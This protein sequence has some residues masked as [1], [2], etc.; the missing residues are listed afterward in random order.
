MSQQ[1][2]NA[3]GWEENK[4]QEQ[5][6]PALPQQIPAA[7]AMSATHMPLS[8][9][10]ATDSADTEMP[11]G[12]DNTTA[13]LP[14]RVQSQ[15]QNLY[16]NVPLLRGQIRLLQLLPNENE[17][18]TIQCRLFR[19]ALDSRGTRL[20]EALSYVWGSRDNRRSIVVNGCD[21]AV[22]ENLY[23]ALL[24]LRD[25]SVERT[26]WIDAIC[27]NQEDTEEKG[28]QVQS[29]AKIYAKATRIIVWLGEEAAGSDQ[30][31]EE[32]RLAADVERYTRRPDNY[33]GILA[34]LQRSW[35][36][37]IWVLQEVA[38]AR[39]ILIK[40][41]SAEVDGYAFCLGL[42]ALKISKELRPNLRAR[43]L[44]VTYLIRGAIFRPKYTTT[45][46]T[47]NFSLNIRPLGELSEMY[48]TRE[49]TDRR[50]KVYALLGMSSD[51]PIAAGLSADYTISWVQLLNKVIHFSLS[52]LLFVGLWDNQENA[53]IEGKGCVL[54]EVSTV[55]KNATWEDKQDVVITWRKVF[56]V[57]VSRWSILTTEKSIQ[58]GDIVCLLQG[59]SKPTIL[60][61]C[62]YHWV[63]IMIAVYLEN[64]LQAAT[65]KTKW[66]ELWESVTVFPHDFQLRW[67]LDMDLDGQQDDNDH[68]CFA[69]FPVPEHSKSQLKGYVNAATRIR[70]VRLALYGEKLSRVA[71]KHL[72][73][74]MA[75]L[76]KGLRSMLTLKKAGLSP[77]DSEKEDAKKL[78]T[79]VNQLIDDLDQWWFLSLAA[80]HGHETFVKFLLDNYKFNPD[81]KT[82]ETALWLATREY[83]KGIAV[84]ELL[85][86]SGK[87]DVNLQ[88]DRGET[89]LH[90]AASKGHEDVVKL[91]LDSG[92]V[93]ANKQDENGQTALHRAAKRYGH[94]VV[95]KLLLDSGKADIDI[96]DGQGRTALNIVRRQAI[97]LMGNGPR[98]GG[99]GGRS[100]R[101]QAWRISP[102]RVR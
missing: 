18:A 14:V 57:P 17:D 78:E 81:A 56:D 72:R 51:N 100:P 64:D 29:M 20:Y 15:K 16:H 33:A 3:E 75:V 77:D 44:S 98:G 24:H 47:D 91:L 94:E 1:L 19:T 39:H 58:E 101:R 22:G 23:A 89:A 27:I 80:E 46:Q 76:E 6:C 102:P 54:G 67:D 41:G 85:L 97:L 10:P 79:M 90:L 12:V 36:Q 11:A 9:A 50:D 32:I 34:L 7:T 13:S 42:N 52:E 5:S 86:G 35:F 96:L 28:H 4:G 2:H 21:L 95:F 69:R 43:I 83:Y 26:I 63:V 93:D 61:P 62:N 73:E 40:C 25:P 8:A 70:N 66:S 60:R 38:A 59:A 49:A 92:K 68:D 88:N 65:G 84:V 87:V 37:R 31:L 45:C 53:F 74:E 30:A 48:H 99:F 55:E 71:N 82:L